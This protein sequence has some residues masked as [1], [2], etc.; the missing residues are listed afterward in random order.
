MRLNLYKSVFC[1]LICLFIAGCSSVVFVADRGCSDTLD[2]LCLLHLLSKWYFLP[3]L[4][5]QQNRND[6]PDS[7]EKDEV[8]PQVKEVV[9][10]KILATCQPLWAKCH[11]STVKFTHTQKYLYEVAIRFVLQYSKDKPHSQGS[12]YEYSQDF[13]GYNRWIR[14]T[15]S[16]ISQGIFFPD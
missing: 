9:S 3:W 13:Q 10:L 1:L 5:K 6:N 2:G 16:L 4:N 15:P 8:N 12:S 7:I 14:H 11:P